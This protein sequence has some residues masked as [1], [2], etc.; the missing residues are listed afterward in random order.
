LKS[1]DILMIYDNSY[2][3]QT[4]VSTL[5]DGLKKN[6]HTLTAI[7]IGQ[8]DWTDD[9]GL[10][11]FLTFLANMI[12]SAHRGFALAR[13]M[14]ERR[15][16]I[17]HAHNARAAL[18]LGY[19]LHIVRRIP[20]VLTI[21]ETHS[22]ALKINRL[23]KKANKIIAISPE[24][25]QR[26][27]RYGVDEHKLCVIPNMVNTE[28]WVPT[29]GAIHG[30]NNTQSY[31]LVW[32]GRA[33]TSKMGVLRVLMGSMPR[34]LVRF[35]NARLFVA[36][37]GPRLREMSELA[38]RINGHVGK[39]AIVML[40]FMPNPAEVFKEADVLIGAGRVALEAMACG[41]PVVVASA[42]EDGALTGGIV[43]G[44]NVCQLSR[45]NFS[46]RSYP[47]R[48]D[49]PSMCEL[50]GRLLV[51]E[52]YRQEVGAWGRSYVEENF[53]IAGVAKCIEAA[54][55]ESIKSSP[56]LPTKMGIRDWKKNYS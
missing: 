5:V 6:G 9:L 7:S 20:L 33:D 13:R 40:G 18:M 53:G 1:Y 10:S 49:S 46:G 12:M 30:R 14:G 44:E 23:Y 25:K 15:P 36:G 48:I 43:T 3:T 56:S 21:H 19:F 31:R 45:C 50:I 37:S 11:S 39:E 2:G 8:L 38:G 55:A 27:L 16:D 17:I 34:I 24:V 22:I 51:D 28:Q 42:N 32:A 35:P 54:Y 29:V 41:K 4:H 52:G 26:I 47:D